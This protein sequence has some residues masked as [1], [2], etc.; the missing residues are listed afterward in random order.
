MRKA[1]GR[2]LLG[3][4]HSTGRCEVE[5]PEWPGGHL[6]PQVLG[7]RAEKMAGGE[8]GS[9]DLCGKAL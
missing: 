5:G 8:K 3:T 4:L 7:T 1:P 2:T 6:A 9:G